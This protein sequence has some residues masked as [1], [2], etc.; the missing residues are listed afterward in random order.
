MA[1]WRAPAIRAFDR[2]GK[3]M[4]IHEDVAGFHRY[5]ALPQAER[6]A[7][8][9]EKLTRLLKHASVHVPYY[10]DVLRDVSVAKS[11]GSIDLSHFAD[12][13]IL[14]KHLVRDNFERL[15]SDD[16]SQRRWYFNSTGGTTGFPMRCIQDSDFGSMAI[17]GEYFYRELLGVRLGDLVVQ[18]W[19]SEREILEGTVGWRAQIM[20]FLRNNYLLSSFRMTPDDMRR[21][22]ELMQA[23]HPVLLIAYVECVY[24][25][26][27]FI[28]KNGCEVPPMKGIISTA[29][30]LLPAMRE[31][32]EQSF[33][34]KVFN[35]Y[36]SREMANMAFDFP[37]QDALEVCTYTHLIELLDD[38]N[39]HCAVGQEGKIIVTGLTNYT[40][41]LIRYQIGD[42]A[43]A[44]TVTEAPVRE[45]LEMC[46]VSGHAVDIIVRRDGTIVSPGLFTHAIGSM[47][48][49]PS[50][51]KVQIVQ[52]D[53][54]FVR[55]KLVVTEKLPDAD[56]FEITRLL[57]A[58]TGEDCTIVFDYVDDLPP[59]PS[60]KMQH[61]IS[62][63]QRD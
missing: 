6:A 7:I 22:I 57:K 41:P 51:E 59:N 13:P 62:N 37:S 52:E 54:D 23:K 58:G 20:S 9:E 18:L 10:R 33:K 40:M 11:D 46:N 26:A 34:S 2:Y 43:T 53:Y 50:V 56:V 61:V 44:H 17:A 29:G 63:V 49:L 12:V 42:V 55:I 45:A 1:S 38:Q 15:T 30:N 35:R 5:F 4:H 48:Y 47:H 39:Q 8:H 14:T 24:E 3:R 27:R 32:I 36:G 19:G 16:L 21:Y 28:M 60:G 31:Q 25:M